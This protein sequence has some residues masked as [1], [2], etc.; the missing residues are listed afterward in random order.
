MADRQRE[1]RKAKLRE[2]RLREEAA[3]QASERRQRMLKLGAAAA[4]GA[5]VIV[6]V[7]ILINQSGS[8]SS[9]G[10]ASNVSSKA[11]VA[12]LLKGIPQSDLTIGAPTAK[13]KL[14]EF[15]D[16]QCPICKEYSETVIQQLINGPVRQ[17][18]LRIEFRNY[19]IISAQSK[20]AGAAALAAGQQ[21]RGW[22]YIELFYRNQG[23]EGTGYVTDPFMTSIAKGAGVP[24]IPKWDTARTDPGLS[25]EMTKTSNQATSYGFSGTPSF[26]MT[27]P[28]GSKVLG[29]PGLSVGPFESAI[30]QVGG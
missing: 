29:T 9:G 6:A 20:D 27:G 7:F 22:N 12:N 18:K 30:A 25:R 26:V 5:I 8:S 23:T 17:G 21:S 14:I 24:D 1:E 4:F 10:N 16:L 15:G 3:A 19:L 28:N 2:S 11:L 13:A